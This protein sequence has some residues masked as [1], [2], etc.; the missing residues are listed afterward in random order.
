[1][2]KE[3]Y[4]VITNHG[5]LVALAIVLLGGLIEVSPIKVNP[6]GWLGER[7]NKKISDEVKSLKS[8]LEDHKVD[9][10]RNDIL[11][12]ANSC[13]NHTK[14]TKEEFDQIIELH[15][16]E[17]VSKLAGPPHADC[18]GGHL[19]SAGAFAGV[20]GSVHLVGAK[21]RLGFQDLRRHHRPVHCAAG[22]QPLHHSH[23]LR[24]V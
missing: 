15:D 21:I 10:W 19:V 7:F 4:D 14:H 18:G 13:M 24:A 23:Q 12:F 1:M 8:E 20:C 3:I 9:S 17:P 22:L 16:D 5:S 11:S 6:I 2:I